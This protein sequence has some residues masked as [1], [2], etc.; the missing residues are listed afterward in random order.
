MLRSTRRP[1]R[2]NVVFIGLVVLSFLL[3]TYDV[4]TAGA[5]GIVTGLRNGAEAVFTPVQKLSSAVT[6]PV[7]NFVDGIANLAG[8]RSENEALAIEVARLEQELAEV[9]VLRAQVEALQTAAN[10]TVPDG[11]DAVEARIF[12][13]GPSGFDNVRSIDKGSADGLGVGMPV[14]DHLGLIGRI[15]V[16]FENQSRV[17]LITDPSVRVGARVVRTGEVG[18]VSGRG[19]GP[20]L[21][22]M[23]DASEVVAEGDQLVTSGGRFPPGLLIGVVVEGA[24]AEAGFALRSTVDPYIDVSGLD[25][26]QVFLETRQDEQGEIESVPPDDAPPIAPPEETP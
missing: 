22:E 12:A 15:D 9:E 13:I 26:V 25:Y 17:R 8:L 3:T 20:L 18:W 14:V 4:Q 5:G 24:R 21:L 11:L 2:T 19:S 23:F 7:V 16:V 10:I 1:D 6:R